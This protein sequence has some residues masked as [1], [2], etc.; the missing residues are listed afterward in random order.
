MNGK[1]TFFLCFVRLLAMA[2][3][4]CASLAA[5]E[6]SSY[7]QSAVTLVQH[8]AKHAGTTTESSLAFTNPNT[9]GNWIAV[10]VRAGYS[11]SQVFTVKDSVGNAYR[12]AGQVGMSSSV[13]LAI[14]Y[15][16]NVKGGANTVTVSDTVSAPLRLAIMEYSGVATANSLDA[17]VTGTGTGTSLTSGTLTTTTNVELLLA[18]GATTNVASFTAGSGYSISDFVPA[19][20]NTKLIAEERIQTAAGPA[21][22]SASIAASDNW[23]MVLAAVKAAGG[24]GTGTTGPTITSLSPASGPVG[25]SVTISGTNFGTSQ[26]TSKVTFNGTV[27]SATN[28]SATSIVATVPT[29]ATTGSVVVTAGGVASNGVLFT[30]AAPT[31]PPTITTEP[32]NQTV[33]AGQTATFAVAATGAGT[34]SY[35][36][37]KNGA[38]VVGATASSYTTPATA[39]TDSGSTFRV[40]VTDSAGSVMSNT[41]TLTVNPA[42]VAPTITTQPANQ[43]VTVGQTATFAVAATGTAPLSYQWQK[44]GTSISGAT[45]SSYTTPATTTADSGSTYRVVVAN[46]AGSATSNAASLT[47]NSVPAPAIQVSPTS[48]NFGNVVTG[49][50]LSQALVI[51]NTGTAT[52]TITQVTVTG[53]AFSAS[54]FSLPL[55]VNAGQN[56]TITVAFLPTSV[57]SVSG[58]V[59][60]VSNAATSPTSVALS[61]SGI[62]PNLTLGI[63]PG[64]LSF[65]NVTTGTSSPT[66]NVTITNTGNA[67]VTI[68]QV[69]ASGAGYSVTG[70]STPVTLTPSQNLVL[71][72][73]FSPTVAGSVSGTISIVS[74]ATGSPATVTLSGSGVLPAQHSVALSWVASTSTVAGY[75]IYRSTVSG[76]GYSKVNT[77]LVGGTAYTDT[78][79]QNGTT[80]YYVTTAVDSS[81]KESA[82]S[83][84]VTAA[85]P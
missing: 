32:A 3:V 38:N 83:N 26:E 14:F 30:V 72:V 37:E 77:S 1:S 54:G 22:A 5:I 43:T 16:E 63:S 28:W 62:A 39:T 59:S 27:A 2:V 49:T 84:Q 44:N 78:S 8:T 55:N 20:P 42:V 76:S 21:S 7:A 33:T 40:V 71:S 29:G 47:V 80:Y 70:G 36:W 12:R 74:N 15:A 25:T 64:S 9:A 61:G 31:A 60:I 79:V 10:C 68:S 13:S 56:S 65:G 45:A 24:G 53:A 81:G 69:S 67:N 73:Q 75:N 4:L 52:L 41:A 51:S 19:E 48:I 50:S 66:E 6:G 11:S 57:V 17:A 23:G 18:V 82:Y 46:S 85:I 34:L 35:Q 58:N